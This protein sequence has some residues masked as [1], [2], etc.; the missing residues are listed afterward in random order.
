MDDEDIIEV[1]FAMLRT[2]L[3]QN[4]VAEQESESLIPS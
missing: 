2:L 3:S 4:K 1:G